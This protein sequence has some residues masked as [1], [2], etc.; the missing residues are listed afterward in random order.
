MDVFSYVT[1]IGSASFKEDDALMNAP[2]YKPR[3]IETSEVRCPD[4]QAT[5]AMKAEIEMCIR[6]RS[7]G[8]FDSMGAASRSEA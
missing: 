8:R 2:D 7:T 1:S 5:E 3:A 6:D 4:E